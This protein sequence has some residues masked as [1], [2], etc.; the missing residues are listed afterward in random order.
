MAGCAGQRC[1]AASVM[2]GVGEVNHIVEQLCDESKIVAG[3]NLGAVISTQAK[4]RI[5]RYITEAEAEGAKVLVDGR[6][7]L[8]REAKADITSTNRD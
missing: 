6:K 4:E 8:W 1:M 7:L 5:E 3:K 2:V